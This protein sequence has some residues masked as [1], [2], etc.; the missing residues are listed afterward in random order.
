[1]L[2]IRKHTFEDY[3]RLPNIDAAGVGDFD[4]NDLACLNEIGD[5]LVASGRH[6]RFGLTLLHSHFYIDDD[7]TLV[8]EI[9]AAENALT[10]RPKRN[11]ESQLAA[12]NICF[13]S[14]HS[15]NGNRLIGLEYAD[16]PM[17]NG[18]TPFDAADQETITQIGRI[19]LRHG[20]IRRFGIRLLHDPFNLADRILV[21]TSDVTNRI[22]ICRPMTVD[23][24]AFR[25]SIPTVFSWRALGKGTE[26]DQVITQSCMQMCKSLRRCNIGRSG[27]TRDSSH[28]ST[29][30]KI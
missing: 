16:R 24:I 27:H 22:L 5:S 11:C 14:A 18:V 23:Q 3:A 26:G 7:E 1:M 10:L 20:K 8:E 6:A 25:D 17:L 29:H 19:I 28:E 30:A 4:D 13:E 2:T 15:P 21:E 9:D 12:T